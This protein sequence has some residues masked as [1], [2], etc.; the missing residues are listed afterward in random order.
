MMLSAVI[1]RFVVV[2]IVAVVKGFVAVAMSTVKMGPGFVCL[3]NP[4]TI[5]L[6]PFGIA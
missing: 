3:P 4:S 1:I 6:S 2:T 5:F